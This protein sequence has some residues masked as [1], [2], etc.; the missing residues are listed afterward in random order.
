MQYNY[1]LLNIINALLNVKYVLLHYVLY[2]L[3]APVLFFSF[4]N[5]RLVC[6]VFFHVCVFACI[7]HVCVCTD[8][9]LPVCM[10]VCLCLYYIHTSAN[11]LSIVTMRVCRGWPD[12]TNEQTNKWTSEWASKRTSEWANKR[13]SD[14]LAAFTPDSVSSS[15]RRREPIL[16]SL[17]H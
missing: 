9:N 11:F 12:R 17:L 1:V 8:T 10:C 4:A 6:A 15:G 5:A 14:W 3:L 2:I 16:K 13:T 7:Q